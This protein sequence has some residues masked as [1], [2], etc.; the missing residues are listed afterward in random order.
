MS[1]KNYLD[2]LDELRSIAQLGLNYS[3]NHHDIENYNRLL[4]LAADN[5]SDIT[6]LSSDEIKNRFK[7]EL[8]Y[9]TPKVGVNG[10]LF[11]EQGQ[12]LLEL[13]SDDLLWGMPGGWVDIG[14][15]P[16]TAIKREF[17]EEA[18]LVVEPMGIIKFYTRLPGEFSQPHTSVHIVYYCKYIS[19]DLKKSYE[20]LELNYM[21]HTKITNWHKDHGL[22][23]QDAALYF[24]KLVI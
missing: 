14:E 11:N 4:Q 1:N 7:Q 16:D 21:D 13:R 10:A 18:N 20:S 19:G 12:L 22:Q 3:K 17:M 9:V 2:L 5:Y 24:N 15:S 6:G 23:A 8:G